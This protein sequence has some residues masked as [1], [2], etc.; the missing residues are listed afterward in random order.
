LKILEQICSLFLLFSVGY[1]TTPFPAKVFKNDNGIFIAGFPWP[2]EAE[3]VLLI[4]TARHMSLLSFDDLDLSPLGYTTAGFPW[5]QNSLGFT[6]FIQVKEGGLK[7]GVFVF[8]FRN[9][10]G[11]ESIVD[12]RTNDLVKSTSIVE[13]GR[14]RIDHAIVLK[15]ASLLESENPRDRETAAIHLGQIGGSEFL[16]ELEDLLTDNS[17]QTVLSD[18]GEERDYF[19][20]EAARESIDM[21]KTSL[22]ANQSDQ[23]NPITI[24]KNPKNHT[25]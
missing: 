23:V 24:P 5:Y 18:E 17:Y 7:R 8:V 16:P 10:I 3:N 9:R 21:I 13:R 19:V 11:E 12:I 14:Y 25:D 15:A 4:R 20:R 22:A 6:D 1:A 2:D